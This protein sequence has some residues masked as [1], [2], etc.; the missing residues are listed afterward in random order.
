MNSIVPPPP[1][2]NLKKL[3]IMMHLIMITFSSGFLCI[4]LSGFYLYNS[5]F[6]HNA[7]LTDATVTDIRRE[8]TRRYYKDANNIPRN[9]EIESKFIEVEF[10][11]DDGDERM[12]TYVSANSKPYRKGDVVSIA[13]NQ[14][15]AKEAKL[16]SESYSTKFFGIGALVAGI[17]ATL[18]WRKVYK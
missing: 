5:W 16:A 8:T 13:Y 1:S 11:A 10:I 6:F 12:R 17:V 15:N 4:G 3:F 14:K 7:K 9:Q 2:Y 18:C